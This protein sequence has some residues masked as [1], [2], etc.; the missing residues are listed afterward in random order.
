MMDA[1]L[2]LASAIKAGTEISVAASSMNLVKP[3]SSLQTGPVG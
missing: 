1:D 2:V 3:V